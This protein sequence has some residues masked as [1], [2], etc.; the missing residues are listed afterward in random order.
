MS[1][2]PN[3]NRWALR[4]LP[5]TLEKYSGGRHSWAFEPAPLLCELVSRGTTF[6]SMNQ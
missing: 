4:N 2:A 5:A 3:G 6:E 1:A